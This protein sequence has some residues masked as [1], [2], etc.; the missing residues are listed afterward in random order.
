MKN[1]LDARDRRVVELVFAG[2]YAAWGFLPVCYPGLKSFRRFAARFVASHEEWAA[3]GNRR[4][5]AD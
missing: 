2:R 1:R 5:L 3:R 4:S